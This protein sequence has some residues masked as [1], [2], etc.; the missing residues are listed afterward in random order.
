MAG[1]YRYTAVLD[2]CVLYPAPLRDLLVSL[3]VDGI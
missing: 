1:H 2:A 3:A